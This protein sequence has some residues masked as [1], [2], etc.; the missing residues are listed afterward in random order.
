MEYAT[1]EREIYVEAAPEIVFDVVSSPEHVQEWWP[2]EAHYEA[3]PGARGDLVFGEHGEEGSPLVVAFDVLEVEPP[4][5]F[6]FRWTHPHGEQP[7][8]GNS[9]L[10]TFAL[11]PRGS[12]TLLRMTES[13][14]REMG[15]EAAVLEQQYRDHESGWDFYLGRIA[16]YVEKLDVRP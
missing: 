2:D 16:P 10:V 11:E 4:H 13:G 9:L 1:I 5:T 14:F 6:S 7:V 3:R 8:T 15:W 12:G